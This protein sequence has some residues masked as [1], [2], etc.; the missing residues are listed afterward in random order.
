MDMYAIRE[1]D[2][3]TVM[4]KATDLTSMN[5]TAVVREVVYPGFHTSGGVWTT[6]GRWVP[7]SRI[8]AL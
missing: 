7:E 1:G 8:E 2:T 4:P 5:M 3:I 6:E